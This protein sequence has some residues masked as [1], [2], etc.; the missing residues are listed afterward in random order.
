MSV[1]SELVPITFG[2]MGGRCGPVGVIEAKGA[3]LMIIMNV[4]RH[5]EDKPEML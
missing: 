3:I 2:V 5:I 1:S 4:A